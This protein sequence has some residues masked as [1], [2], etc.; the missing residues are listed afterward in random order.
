MFIPGWAV[1]ACFL[2]IQARVYSSC[3]YSVRGCAVSTRGTAFR[4][5]DAALDKHT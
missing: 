1:P 4:S 3:E 5:A 2:V